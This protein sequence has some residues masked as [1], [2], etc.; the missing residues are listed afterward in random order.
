[1]FNELHDL[2]NLS[3]QRNYVLFNHDISPPFIERSAKFICF[4]H[5]VHFVHFLCLHQDKTFAAIPTNQSQIRLSLRY[6]LFRVPWW[7]LCHRHPCRTGR[8]PLWTQRSVPQ[9]VGQPEIISHLI[10]FEEQTGESMKQT[11]QN[12]YHSNKDMTQH[13][14]NKN[15]SV[16]CL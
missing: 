14:I 2:K 9:S 12:C 4:L 1:M 13:T 5:F 15:H 6:L 7:W 10:F 11:K 3:L 8:M 16:L